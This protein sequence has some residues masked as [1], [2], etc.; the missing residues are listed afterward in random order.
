[1]GTGHAAPLGLF[2]FSGRYYKH[3]APNG[4][5][6]SCGSGTFQNPCRPDFPSTL[7]D[8]EQL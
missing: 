5:G 1:M 2:S 7:I 4:A 8:R 6:G 3:D